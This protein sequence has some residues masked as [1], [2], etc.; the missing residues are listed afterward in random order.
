MYDP[1]DTQPMA[2]IPAPEDDSEEAAYWQCPRCGSPDLA[3]AYPIDYSDKFRQMQLAP[4]SLKLARI[5]RLLRPFRR[6]VNIS[7]RVCRDCG[8]VMF[9]VDPDEFA[10]AER[11]FSQR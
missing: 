11:R 8:L 9:E 7:A 2:P 10:E 1:A 3:S 5:S 4:R 6:M